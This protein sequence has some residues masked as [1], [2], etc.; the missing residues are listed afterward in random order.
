MCDRR[1]LEYIGGLAHH[2]AALIY[3]SVWYTFLLY[4]SQVIMFQ[5]VAGRRGRLC[6]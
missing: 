6:L 5:R 3:P 4:L 1:I 2:I